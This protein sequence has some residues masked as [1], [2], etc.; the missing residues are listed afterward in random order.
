M[1]LAEPRIAVPLGDSGE[2]RKS[3]RLGVEMPV[4]VDGEATVTHD[5]SATG[6]CFESDRAYVPGEQLDLLIDYLL[7]GHNYPLKCR[8]E[9][10]RC[11]AQGDR[12]SVGARLLAPLSEEPGDVPG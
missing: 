9:V 1:P 10:T 8:A 6:L 7:D 11:D 5:L 2:K 12:F 4:R 3:A